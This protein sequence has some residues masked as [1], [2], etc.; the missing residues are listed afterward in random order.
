MHLRHF[1]DLGVL[2]RN[3]HQLPIANEIGGLLQGL[4]DQRQHGVVGHDCL[5]GDALQGASHHAVGVH[6]FVEILGGHLAHTTGDL[7]EVRFRLA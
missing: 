4:A 2:L 5:G 6:G 1:D 7:V 3:R